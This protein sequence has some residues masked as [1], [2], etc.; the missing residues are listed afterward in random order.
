MRTA[1]ELVNATEVPFARPTVQRTFLPRSLVLTR[2]V[3][4]LPIAPNPSRVHVTD[5]RS[6]GRAPTK[7]SPPQR[8]RLPALATPITLGCRKARSSGGAGRDP[9][10]AGGGGAA[11]DPGGAGGGGSVTVTIRGVVL[12]P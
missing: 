2:Y 7:R 10:T 8:R 5:T 9:V 3:R 4:D 1:R 11:G 6:V 12:T